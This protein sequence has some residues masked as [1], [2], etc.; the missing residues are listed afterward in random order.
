MVDKYNANARAAGLSEAQMCAV[1]GDLLAGTEGELEGEEWHNFDIC[2]VSMG[3]HHVGI[4]KVLLR[5]LMERVKEGGRVVVID[6][7]DQ[8]RSLIDGHGLGDGHGHKHGHGQGKDDEQG[9]GEHH[10]A[11]HT[12]AFHGFSEEQMREMFSQAGC[13]SSDFV[14]AAEPSEVPYDATGKKQMFF[15][16]GTK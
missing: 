8:G 11:A 5:K 2:I 3:L 7:V 4:P 16:K 10:S 15:A 1:V 13:T 12:V 6:W 9:A 14:L